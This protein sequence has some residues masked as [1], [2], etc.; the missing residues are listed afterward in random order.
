[1]EWGGNRGEEE[2]RLDL[3]RGQVWQWQHLPNPHPLPRFSSGSSPS[4]V[5]ILLVQVQVDPT[6]YPRVGEEMFL[7]PKEAKTSLWNAVNTALVPLLCHPG[8]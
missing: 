8:S 2:S 4:Q 1:M 5:G 6:A 3:R 7:Y